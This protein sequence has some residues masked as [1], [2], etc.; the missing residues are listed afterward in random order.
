[1]KNATLYTG[2]YYR[3]SS[4]INKAARTGYMESKFISHIENIWDGYQYNNSVLLSLMRLAD[5]YLMYAEATAE[6]Y[7]SPTSHATAASDTL[8]ALRAV[9]IVR[10]RAGVGNV[11]SAYTGSTDAFMPELRRERAVELAF[12]GHRF[13]DLRRWKLFTEQ[14]YTYKKAVYFTRASDY[15]ESVGG[16]LGLNPQDGHVTGLY[17]NT[18]VERQLVSK[19][20]WLPFLKADVSLYSGF[21]QN[22]GW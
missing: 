18:L 16:T 4:N 6:G 12:E 13:N 7:G 3:V 5:V 21:Y 20:Y 15:L 17:E 9:N 10:N 14:P 8:T 1:V 2:G 19:H 22:P 11:A